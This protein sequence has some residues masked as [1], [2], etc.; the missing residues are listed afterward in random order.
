MLIIS[1]FISKQKIS[2]QF[3]FLHPDGVDV[4]LGAPVLHADVLAAEMAASDEDEHLLTHLRRLGVLPAN[5]KIYWKTSK[6]LAD[7]D[8]LTCK[9]TPRVP[10]AGRSRSS[11]RR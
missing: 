1:V 7:H 8:T 5:A 4:N 10:L 3:D 11:A 2:R 9:G 6:C